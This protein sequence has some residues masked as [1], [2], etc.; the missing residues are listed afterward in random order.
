MKTYALAVGL[1]FVQP[2]L[3]DEVG[4]FVSVMILIVMMIFAIGN[5]MERIKDPE[6]HTQNIINDTRGPAMG[7]FSLFTLVSN[8][9]MLYLYKTWGLNFTDTS[10]DGEST[11]LVCT[12]CD[13]DEI[14]ESTKEKESRTVRWIH[15]LL[16]PGCN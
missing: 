1:R 3:I 16:H 7:C 4:S 14:D 8:G 15:S 5:V 13:D 12:V 9:L 10:A 2:H 6:T 11:G